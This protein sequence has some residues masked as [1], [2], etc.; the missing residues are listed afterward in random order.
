MA[1]SSEATVRDP[2]DAIGSGT[3]DGT[4]PSP[5]LERT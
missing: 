3:E 1:R 4:V 5:W 2:Y